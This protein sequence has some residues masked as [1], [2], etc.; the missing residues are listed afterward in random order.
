MPSHHLIT[1]SLQKAQRPA[2]GQRLALS[3]VASKVPA[4][5]ST[6]YGNEE[7]LYRSLSSGKEKI[8]AC[9]CSSVEHRLSLLRGSITTATTCRRG[10]RQYLVR[11]HLLLKRRARGTAVQPPRSQSYGLNKLHPPERLLII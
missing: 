11:Q 4:V 9:G 6:L 8:C 2:T 7:V 3:D 1:R 10:L 5:K